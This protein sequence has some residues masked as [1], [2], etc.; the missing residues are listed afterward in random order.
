MFQEIA[1]RFSIAKKYAQAGALIEAFEIIIFGDF[2]DN[3]S[4]DTDNPLIKNENFYALVKE[5]GLKIPDADFDPGEHIKYDLSDNDTM[6][7]HIDTSDKVPCVSLFLSGRTINCFLIIRQNPHNDMYQ[8]DK[9]LIGIVNFQGGVDASYEVPTENYDAAEE[10]LPPFLK[11]FA[12]G[13]NE[14]A[15]DDWSVTPQEVDQTR[16]R[17]LTLLS[18]ALLKLMRKPRPHMQDR[19]PPQ[20][21]TK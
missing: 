16:S 5:I 12:N 6:T 14:A 15:H 4:V 11:A 18:G 17:R 1:D 13:T 9:A 2:E 3:P 7:L 21:L 10:L 20:A 19:A 8:V